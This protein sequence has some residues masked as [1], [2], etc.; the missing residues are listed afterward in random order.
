MVKRVPFRASHLMRMVLQ[1]AQEWMY[2]V[3]GPD[4][5]KSLEGPWAFSGLRD[6]GEVLIC[7]GVLE[8]WKGRGLLWAFVSAAAGPHMLSIT[9]GVRRFLAEAPHPRLEA[10]V[11]HSFPQGQTWARMLGMTLETPNAR[12]FLENGAD[13]A[14]Y[15]RIR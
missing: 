10:A 9:R 7:G 13:C 2:S 11:E 5:A 4:E 14:I 3:V 6:D 15:V 1:P 12:K 8:Y